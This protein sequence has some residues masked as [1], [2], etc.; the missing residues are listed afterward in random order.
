MGIISLIDFFL[1]RPYS[2]PDISASYLRIISWYY[3][4]VTVSNFWILNDGAIVTKELLYFTL[5]MC[6]LSDLFFYSLNK[7]LEDKIMQTKV[8]N[9]LP[10]RL[11][12]YLEEIMRLVL[13][14]EKDQSSKVKLMAYI[15]H[16]LETCENANC[17]CIKFMKA[18]YDAGRIAQQVTKKS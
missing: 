4:A 10:Y 5:F 13:E 12:I 16:H 8:K 2:N 1:N 18:R 11:D 9:Y 15:K 3:A 6:V 14:S 17:P 7:Y